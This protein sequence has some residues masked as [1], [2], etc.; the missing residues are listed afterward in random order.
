MVKGYSILVFLTLFNI[1][2]YSQNCDELQKKIRFLFSKG[3]YNAALKIAESAVSIC[4]KEFGHEST[5]NIKSLNALAVIYHQTGNYTKADTTYKECL[6]IVN[7]LFGQDNP[8]YATTLNSLAEL[9]FQMNLYSKAL[10]LQLQVIEIRKKILGEEN[11]DYAKSLNNLA[12][13]YYTLGK[14]NEAEP[15]FIQVQSIYKSKLGDQN[16]DYSVLLSDLSLLYSMM[17]N[18]NKAIIIQIQAVQIT[19]DLFGENA[20]EY[21][22]SLRNLAQIYLHTG[23]FRQ[24][25]ELNSQSLDIIKRQKGE[26]HDYVFNLNIKA[27]HYNRLGEYIKAEELYLEALSIRKRILGEEHPGYAASLA[28]LAGQYN[29]MGN[30]DKSEALYL[31]ALNIRKRVLGEENLEYIRTL[32]N[33]AN[34]YNNLKFYSKAENIYTQ[35]LSL[36]EKILGEENL[37]YSNAVNNLATIYTQVGNYAKAEPLMIKSLS[38]TKKLLGPSDVRYAIS[39]NNL[40]NLYDKLKN[41]SKAEEYFLEALRITKNVVGENHPSFAL[42]LNNL[43]ALYDNLGEYTKAESYHIKAR[44][45]RRKYLGDEHPDYATSLSN[46]AHSYDL[47]NKSALASSQYGSSIKIIKNNWIDNLSFLNSFEADEYINSNEFIFEASLSFL[48][49][50][51]REQVKSELFDFSIFRKNL[52]FNT[53]HLFEKTIASL[54]DSLIKLKWKYYKEIGFQIN[55]QLQE[56]SDDQKKLAELKKQ[57]DSLEKDLI[58]S[59]PDFKRILSNYNIRWTDI[60]YKIKSKDAVLDF[61][62]FKYYDGIWTGTVKFGVFILRPGWA[63]PQFMNLFDEEQ[64]TSLFDSSNAPNS[65][66]NLYFQNNGHSDTSYNLSLYK[67][68][69]KP[70]DSLLKG[71]TKVYIS[72]SGLLNR[73]SFSAIPTPEGG[74]L[75]DRFSIEQLTNIRTIAESIPI[76]KESIKSMVLLGGANFDAEPTISNPINVNNVSTNTLFSNL[77]SL[78]GTK[79]SYLAGTD[80]EIKAIKSIVSTKSLSL[81]VF[82]GTN[83]SEEI[84]KTIGSGRANAPS[85]LHIATHG[86][87][88]ANTNKLP[89]DDRFLLQQDSRINV[90]RTSEDPLTRAGLVMAGGNKVWST[91]LPYPNHEDGILTAREV[92]ELNLS[93]CILATLSACET[94]LGEIKGSEGVFGLQRAF[95]MAGVKYLIVSLWKVPDAQTKE[96]MEY[97]Y[98]SWLIQ[99]I[100]IRESFQQAQIIMSKKYPPYQWASFI[101]VE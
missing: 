96:F 24:A 72:P 77:R 16:F 7:K 66:N 78:H 87:A 44:D 41:Y 100:P 99:E 36:T 83:A 29:K 51:P 74:R 56:S 90:F 76:S 43:A 68:I 60:K 8:F 9:Y 47:H 73:V 27:D 89:E 11:I 91:G 59:L 88:F 34:L 4:S 85:V 64:L 18:Y 55:K 84:V 28:L 5:K 70:L 86:F 58:V 6:F 98:R 21:A 22:N 49:R 45:I 32:N 82:S 92:S 80:N 54:N 23:Q 53:T 25:D 40:A 42:S 14:Y 67:L 52:L 95:K 37:D 12:R 13:L 63:E 1:F 39:L 48:S 33:L 50:H 75:L 61:V 30:Y 35:T 65:I 38:I 20:F 93:G 3:E 2:S 69:W 19:K 10:P 81:N 62:R 46:L 31:R 97:F 79:W 57:K 71:V 101:L 94:G 15:L 17:S 26:S